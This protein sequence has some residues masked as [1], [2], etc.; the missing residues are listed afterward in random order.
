[1]IDLV[2]NKPVAMRDYNYTNDMY[3]PNPHFH[4]FNCWGANEANLIE[5]ISNRDYMSIF[6]LVRSAV[7]GISLYDTAVVG[8]FFNYCENRFT[9]KKCLKVPGREEFISFKEA[10]ALED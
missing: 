8:A 4:E 9:N 6:N 7:A 3:I 1:M 2:N 10:R 5:A